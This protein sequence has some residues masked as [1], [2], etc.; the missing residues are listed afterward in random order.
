[1]EIRYGLVSISMVW[2]GFVWFG[3]VWFGRVW[4]GFVGIVWYG[5]G[6]GGQMNS[7]FIHE[8]ISIL[9]YNGLS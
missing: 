1:M 6:K 8:E 7:E 2:Y 4:F 5:G 9:V 3:M